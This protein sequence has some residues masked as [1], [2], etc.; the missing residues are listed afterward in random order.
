M[1]ELMK[2]DVLERS[3]MMQS[4]VRPA[5]PNRRGQARPL[6]GRGL[7]KRRRY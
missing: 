4:G 2:R 1:M 5:R 6:R 3:Q 7:Q